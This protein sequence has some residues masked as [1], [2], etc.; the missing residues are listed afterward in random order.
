MYL[1]YT[2]VYASNYH[3]TAITDQV[4][5]LP[6]ENILPTS[7]G[8]T[9][10]IIGVFELTKLQKLKCN[11]VCPEK[12]SEHEFLGNAKIHIHILTKK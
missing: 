6:I 3:K 11:I 12:H 9:K 7:L 8:F 2:H 10:N 5:T 1:Y 4:C